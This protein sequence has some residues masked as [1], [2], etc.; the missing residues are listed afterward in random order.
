M[1]L[2][3]P[4]SAV[5]TWEKLIAHLGKQDK[6]S[7]FTKRVRYTLCRQDARTTRVLLL[8][9]VLHQIGNCCISISCLSPVT[10]PQLVVDKKQRNLNKL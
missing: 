2:I 8:I 1:Y 10:F 3:T 7:K 4:G 9:S 5:S 6:Y